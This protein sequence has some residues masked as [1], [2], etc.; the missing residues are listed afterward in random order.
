MGRTCF[1][2]NLRC[3]VHHG[4]AVASWRHRKTLLETHCWLVSGRTE[5]QLIRQQWFIV[6]RVSKIVMLKWFIWCASIYE[7]LWLFDRFSL[8]YTETNGII[9]KIHARAFVFYMSFKH[10]FEFSWIKFVLLSGNKNFYSNH[11]NFV[12]TVTTCFGDSWRGWTVDHTP[13]KCILASS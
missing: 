13:R 6:D 10:D 12:Q 11:K 3:S 9:R 5:R 4:F 8:S 2:R 7:C 1:H